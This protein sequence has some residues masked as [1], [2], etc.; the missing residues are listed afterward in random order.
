MAMRWL[1]IVGVVIPFLGVVTALP[2]V[3]R[4]VA[5]IVIGEVLPLSG[6]AAP[7]G[8][9]IRAGAEIAAEEINAEGGIKALGGARV[10]L[11]FGDSK[12]TPDGGMAET[13]R[14]IV[15]EKV[16]LL[17]GAFQSGVTFPATDVAER[18]Q[19][20]WLVNTAAKDE[21]TI[22]RGFQYVFRDFKTMK[23]DVEEVVQAMQYLTQVTGNKPRTLAIL[24]E[25]A[26]WGRAL[27]AN[28]RK[29]F[30]EAGYQIVFD[31]AYLPGQTDFTAQILTLKTVA[32]DMLHICMYTPAHILFN[33]QVMEHQLYIPYGILSYGSGSE[34]PTFY[35]AVPPESVEYMFVEEDWDFRAVEHA[36]WYPALNTKVRDRLGYDMNAYVACGYG[37]LYLAK[38]ILE[39]AIYDANLATYRRHIRDAMARTDIT[40]Q[41]CQRIARQANGHT[42]CPALIRGVE[43]IVFNEHNQNPYAYGLVSQVLHGR[44]RLFFAGWAN[45]PHGAGIPGT[46]PIWPIPTWEERR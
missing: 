4:T 22:G 20:P 7:Q 40:P 33:Q 35:A 28:A 13:K 5:S 45:P 41:T 9:Q 27:A 30:P 37:A 14:L 18:Y 43:R 42:Y 21:I 38:D 8:A 44:R 1:L 29:L 32:P 34:D 2:A 31:E 46:T 24:C 19:T 17:Q 23:M 39:R 10:Q 6:N 36:P 16:V 26:D 12:S 15:R 11:V 25:S 3:A